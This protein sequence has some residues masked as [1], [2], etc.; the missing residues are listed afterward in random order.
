MAGREREVDGRVDG[1]VATPVGDGRAVEEPLAV[2]GPHRAVAGRGVVVDDDTRP[3]GRRWAAHGT[4][5]AIGNS[6]MS[7]APTSRNAGI[8]M[9]ISRFGTTV[10]TA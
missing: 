7:V 3:S 6:T 1:D 2:G 4:I 9:L 10:S 5:L 8:K